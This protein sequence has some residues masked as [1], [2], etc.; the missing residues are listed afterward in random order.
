MCCLVK[1]D[2]EKCKVRP[3]NGKI[4]QKRTMENQEI[5]NNTRA[6]NSM[7]VFNSRLDTNN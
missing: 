5:K 2:I 1:E 4:K 7:A 6:K 3:V